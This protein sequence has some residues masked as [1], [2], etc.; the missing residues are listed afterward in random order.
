VGPMAMSV[1]V[2]RFSRFKF[3]HVLSMIG[4]MVR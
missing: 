4:I 2:K 1:N 3:A